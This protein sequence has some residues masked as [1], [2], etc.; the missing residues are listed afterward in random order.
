MT[1]WTIDSKQSHS[2]GGVRLLSAGM[3]VKLWCAENMLSRQLYSDFPAF[4]STPCTSWSAV[5]HFDGFLM[6][7]PPFFDCSMAKQ[8]CTM[9]LVCS[10]LPWWK[11]FLR[12]ANVTLTWRELWA[13]ILAP[14]KYNQPMHAGTLHSVHVL[15]LDRSECLTL[16]EWSLVVLVAL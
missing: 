16:T 7:L 6:F 9:L 14:F 8:H 5:L 3:L 15:Q 2:S 1:K 13:Y 10:W 11:C 4:H 12:I